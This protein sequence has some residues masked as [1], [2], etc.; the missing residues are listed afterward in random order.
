MGSDVVDVSVIIPARNVAHVIGAQ[1]DALARQRFAGSW[2]VVVVDDRSTDGTRSVVERFSRVLP[3][4][5]IVSTAQGVNAAHARNT[6]VTA[7]RGRLLLFTDADDVVAE[8]WLPVMAGA[9]GDAHIVAGRLDVHRLNAPWVRASQPTT[10]KQGLQVWDVGGR[11]WLEHAAGPNL[12]VT[13]ELWETVGAFD[14]EIDLLED[15]DFCF[16]AQLAGYELGFVPDSVV[17][18]RLRTTLGGIYRQAR[19]WG[20]ASV[21]IQR[22]YVPFGMPPP[23][24][25][26]SVLSWGRVPF[27]LLAVR[28]RGD[29]ARWLHR[30][31]WRVGR[32]R[33]TIRRV[34]RGRERSR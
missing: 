16:R 7:A 26:R 21:E 1:L 19:D 13:R 15:V 14:P 2:E 9:L 12:G 17:H 6:G 22:R 34:A 25:V 20:A 4:L 23:H 24:P 31:G 11:T 27:E 5:R 30:L 10:Q 29:L 28:D 8:D 3:G 32:F 33:G 18:Y